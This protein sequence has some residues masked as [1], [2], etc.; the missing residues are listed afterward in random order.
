M[1]CQIRQYSGKLAVSRDPHAFV[2]V[3]NDR[4]TYHHVLKREMIGYHVVPT[5]ERRS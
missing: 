5:S 2:T 1:K 4:F 3:G